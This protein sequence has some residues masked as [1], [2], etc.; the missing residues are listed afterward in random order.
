[1]GK[2]LNK[3]QIK[4]GSKAIKRHAKVIKIACVTSVGHSFAA[5]VDAFVCV[6][7]MADVPP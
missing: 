6:A 4:D 2:K 7:L 5:F 3:N 1:M